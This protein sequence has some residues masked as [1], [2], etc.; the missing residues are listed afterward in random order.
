MRRCFLADLGSPKHIPSAI[1]FFHS[2]AFSNASVL[3]DSCPGEDYIPDSEQNNPKAGWLGVNKFLKDGSGHIKGDDLRNILFLVSPDNP[4]TSYLSGQSKKISLNVSVRE[5]TR[6]P[7]AATKKRRQD[8][9][10]STRTK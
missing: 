5:I 3:C 4:Q 8:L 6:M 1:R 7:P 9:E 10:K 2:R